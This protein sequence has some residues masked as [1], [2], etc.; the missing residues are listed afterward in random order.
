MIPDFLVIGAQKSGTTWLDRNLRSHPDIWLPP[1]KEIHFFDFPPLIPFFFLLFAPERPVRCWAKNRM[2][3]DFK[4]VR[5]G[6]QS[7][8]WYLKYYIGVRTQRWYVSLFKPAAQ[9]IAGEITPRYAILGEKHIAKVHQLMPN[10]KIIYLLRNPIDRIWSDLAM[11]NS[12]RFGS[13][14]LHTATAEEID[15]FIQNAKHLASSRY[16]NNLHRW[17]KFYG[18]EQIFIGFQDQIRDDPGQLIKDIC[19]FLAIDDSSLHLSDLIHQKINSHDYPEIPQPMA[20]SL[21]KL[22]LADIEGLHERFDNVYTRQWLLTA[23]AY[24]RNN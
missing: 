12:T 19:Q 13:D 10:G 16:I 11:F 22:L 9:Q 18:S 24:L 20:G 15:K 1:E 23:Q 3:R 4:K 6:E 7:L 8:G 21:A 14:G 2:I 17:E 5:G